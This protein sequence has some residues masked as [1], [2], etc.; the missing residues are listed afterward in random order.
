MKGVLRLILGLA[1]VAGVALFAAGAWAEA[2]TGKLP[3][4]MVVNEAILAL[5]LKE[6]KGWLECRELAK[7]YGE[8]ERCRGRLDLEKLGFDAANIVGA[9]LRGAYLVGADLRGAVLEWVD[10]SGANLSASDFRGADLSGANLSQAILVGANFN[11]VD[12]G[13]CKLIGADLLAA[14]LSGAKLSGANLSGANLKGA[15]VENALFSNA[16]FTDAMYEAVI[17]APKTSY[18]FGMKGVSTLRFE[19]KDGHSG[20]L[21]LRKAF[22]NAGLRDLEREA[23]YVIEKHKLKYEDNVFEKAIY[24][25]IDLTCGFGLD[26]GKPLQWLIGLIPL[27]ALAYV[28][29]IR[30]RTMRDGIFVEWSKERVRKDLGTDEPV[31]LERKGFA[32]YLWALYFSCLSAFHIGWRDLSV[33]SW[34]VRLQRREY[35]LRATGWPRALAGLQSILSVYLLAMWLVTTFGRPFG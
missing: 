9:D 35:V 27:F 5:M 29:P 21:Y 7:T 33:G 23:T 1:L 22:Q 25:L 13:G 20:A 28:I 4:G 30:S 10:L 18:L 6:H 34:I 17:G 32:A 26:P 16:T 19:T 2:W 14:D 31:R 12:L 3:G 11:G 24:S 8:K 15:V